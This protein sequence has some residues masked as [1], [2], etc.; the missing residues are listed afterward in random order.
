MHHAEPGVFPRLKCQRVNII[1]PNRWV[2][3]RH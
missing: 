2:A 1:P 3:G